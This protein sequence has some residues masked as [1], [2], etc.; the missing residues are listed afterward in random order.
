MRLEDFRLL[1]QNTDV[2]LPRTEL[3][4]DG[5]DSNPRRSA[6]ETELEPLQSTP[7]Y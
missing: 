5:W 3:S 1:V 7:Q 4:C 2:L 6:Y